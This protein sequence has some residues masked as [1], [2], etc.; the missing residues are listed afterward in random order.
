MAEYKVDEIK[1]KYDNFKPLIKKDFKSV[2]KEG[3]D[4]EMLK[5]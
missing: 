1:D 4:I 5:N 3:W 2:Y